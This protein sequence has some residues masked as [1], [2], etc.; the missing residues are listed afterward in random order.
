MPPRNTTKAMNADGAA[1]KIRLWVSNSYVFQNCHRPTRTKAQPANSRLQY[2]NFIVS[3][4][5]RNSAGGGMGIP[6]A[7]RLSH[8]RPTPSLRPIVFIFVFV[9]VLVSTSACPCFFPHTAFACFGTFACCRFLRLLFAF[10][11]NSCLL[12]LFGLFMT[13]NSPLLHANALA[14]R[15]TP[16]CVGQYHRA[17]GR[18][19]HPQPPVA[20]DEPHEQQ[21]EE[22]YP[23]D[24]EEA[25]LAGGK[26][27]CFSRRPAIA[28]EGMCVG[29][30]DWEFFVVGRK[31]KGVHQPPDKLPDNNEPDGYADEPGDFPR[32]NMARGPANRVVSLASVDLLEGH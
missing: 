29:P 4:H 21:T 18:T 7:A 30:A 13:P 1:S 12:V 22:E 28:A 20:K 2:A 16:A 5:I 17:L 15:L 23:K 8:A 24:D 26:F 25:V 32:L 3:P 31:L 10:G 11:V 19:H 6:H 27:A 14:V 9:F